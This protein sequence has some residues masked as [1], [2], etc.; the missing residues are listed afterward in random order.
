MEKRISAFFV[1]LFISLI[2]IFK[3]S[4]YAANEL[5][6]KDG[7]L[8]Y[9]TIDT[10][11][12][13]TT[14]WK[15]V[16][17]TVTMRKCLGSNGNDGYPTKY[18][19]ATIKLS[20]GN[21]SSENISGGR[22]KTTFTISES[23]FTKE[24]VNAG[25][26]NKLRDGGTLYLNGIFK[27]V[28]NDKEVGGTID[29][30]KGIKYAKP[31]KNPD[32]FNDRFDIAVTYDAAAQKIVVKYVTDSGKLIQERTLDKKDWKKPGEAFSYTLSASKLYN[33]KE[34]VLEESYFVFNS[35]P[36]V[37][38]LHKTLEYGYSLDE[39]R[40]VTSTQRLKGVTIYAVMSREIVDEDDEEETIVFS[41]YNKAMADT[42]IESEQPGN[43]TYDVSA[44]IPSGEKVYINTKID[45]YLYY[46]RLKKIIGEKTYN[47]TV[48]KKYVLK[49]NGGRENVTLSKTVPITRQYIYWKAEK[50]FIYRLKDEKVKNGIFDNDIVL[51]NDT[52]IKECDYSVLSTHIK[53]PEYDSVIELPG[54]V[55]DGG[56][57][58]PVRPT[59]D[60]FTPAD[61][62]VGEITVRNDKVIV[63]DKTIISDEWKRME[64][65]YPKTPKEHYNVRLKK[66]N[67]TIPISCKNDV[68]DSDASAEYSLIKSYNINGTSPVAVKT[69][70]DIFVN[71]ISVFT[72]V[73]C[74]GLISNMR[75]YSQQLN[76]DRSAAGIILG[77]TFKVKISNE[78]NSISEMGY[79]YNNYRRFVKNNYVT[80]P[81]DVYMDGT[82]YK[83][84]T[85]IT[86]TEEITS[87]TLPIWVRE[88]IYEVEF[89]SEAVNNYVN[90][91]YRPQGHNSE[92]YEYSAVDNVKVEISGRMYGFSVYDVSDYPLWEDVFRE[93]GNINWTTYKAGVNNPDGLKTERNSLYTLPFVKGS[94]PFFQ[95][96]GTLKAGYTMRMSIDTIGGMNTFSDY[97]Y[98]KPGFYFVDKKGNRQ[99]VDVYYPSRII[100]DGKTSNS[101]VK[102]GSETD[103]KNVK[104]LNLYKESLGVN[105]S[106]I[107]S[108]VRIRNYPCFSNKLF[109]FG[110]I[111]IPDNL[112][113]YFGN[114]VWKKYNLTIPENIDIDTV[115]KCAQRWYFEYYLPAGLRIAVKDSVGVDEKIDFSD[116]KWLKNG[117]LVLNFNIV[118]L[119][120]K[121]SYLDY[122]NKV[123]NYVYGD[124]NMW[125]M[126]GM[127]NKKTDYDGN[128]FS[129][130]YG[131]VALFEIKNSVATDY[132][133]GGTH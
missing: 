97:I 46:I 106:L 65:K 68:Y 126:E 30:L 34:Y 91:Y 117:Y 92:Y 93:N 31:W 40:K 132:V 120:D 99:E 76:P 50:V 24:L 45:E 62:S 123:N 70:N 110:K 26:E 2:Y 111:I 23:I 11:A 57:N 128:Q 95:N 35:K 133:S 103:S 29:N 22:V 114:N 124:C 88:G 28:V 77:K 79:Y 15:T 66:R 81:F 8:I 64:G 10:K 25:F 16:G 48:K 119:K 51:E 107:V 18:Q 54:E 104:C 39:I 96:K 42:T 116:S 85:T 60:F 82:Y 80:F 41:N 115:E 12:T 78:G 14:R 43:E 33:Q 7:K 122:Y 38:Q 59:M 105:R 67:I 98:I 94:H 47:V 125:E 87:F 13:S 118:A 130:S 3:Q 6:I 127:D 121:K 19:H 5:D 53:E 102:I 21:V 20:D 90:E 37:K 36:K 89:L 113:I 100:K 52:T 131:D 112:Q 71:S 72:P 17:F 101:L 55:I 69:L 49:W 109:T 63:A 4:S 9:T 27:I 75:K 74:D 1:I 129:I 86:L 73:V 108:T 58:K 61:D 83:S 56:N 84:G 32:D 44:A